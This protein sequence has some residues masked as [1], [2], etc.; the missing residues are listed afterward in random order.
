MESFAEN[1]LVRNIKDEV[2]DGLTCKGKEGIKDE[3]GNNDSNKRVETLEKSVLNFQN[4]SNS[5]YKA[6]TYSILE[7]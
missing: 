6:R 3:P 1:I 4:E 5:M 2:K 7:K